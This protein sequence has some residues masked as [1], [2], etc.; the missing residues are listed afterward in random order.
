MKHKKFFA[1]LA[2]LVIAS[3]VLAACQPAATPTEAPPPETE[4][5]VELGVGW[6]RILFYWREIQP[7][8]PE[9]WNKAAAYIS[10]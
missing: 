2:I 6:E 5:A 9:D 4:E 10:L 8:G 1:L 7:T 3:M